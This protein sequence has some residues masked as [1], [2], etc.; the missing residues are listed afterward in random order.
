MCVEILCCGCLGVPVLPRWNRL[1]GC[2]RI[3]DRFVFV[4]ADTK[5]LRVSSSYCPPVLEDL[6]SSRCC[7]V[8]VSVPRSSAVTVSVFWVSSCCPWWTAPL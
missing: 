3:A 8:A 6:F 7:F 5:L 2:E 4:L 1:A